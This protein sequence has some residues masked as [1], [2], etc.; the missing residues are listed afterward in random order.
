M[1]WGWGGF[2]VTFAGLDLGVGSGLDS[3]ELAGTTER[4]TDEPLIQ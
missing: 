3:S 1:A 4:I 2:R